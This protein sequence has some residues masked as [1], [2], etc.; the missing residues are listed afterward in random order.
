[1]KKYGEAAVVEMVMQALPAIAKNVAEPL[2]KVDKITMYGPDNSTKLISDIVTGTSQ[3]TEGLLSGMG[4]DVKA[5]L[6]GLLGGKLSGC[7]DTPQTP[8]VV[9]VHSDVN[10][11][12]SAPS[13][14][15]F[16]T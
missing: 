4:V 8:V 3:I 6:A 1:M 15:P 7:S 16:N 10:P 11:D 14:A 9:N 12:S 13:P 5:L 2:S